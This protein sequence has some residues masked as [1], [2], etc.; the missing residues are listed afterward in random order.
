MLLGWKLIDKHFL[1]YIDN[2]WEMVN[3]QQKI[4]KYN[5]FIFIR[6]SAVNYIKLNI[7]YLFLLGTVL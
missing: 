2:L 7:I 5:L 4:I 3:L 6:Y 1:F